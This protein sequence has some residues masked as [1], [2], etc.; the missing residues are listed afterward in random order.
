MPTYQPKR[1]TAQGIEEVSF[2]ISSI[3]GLQQ[4]LDNIE[5]SPSQSMP[6]I[7]VGSIT[8]QMGT[9]IIK[10]PGD[11]ESV[12]EL[13]EGE[14]SEA[15][16]E[17]TSEA[18]EAPIAEASEEP[19]DEENFQP[20]TNVLNALIISVEIISGK[21]Q[22]G[23]QVQVCTRTLFTYNKGR[24]RKMRLRKQW[25]VTITEANLENRFI[26][27]PIGGDSEEN[28]NCARLFNSNSASGG[29]FSP[30]YI[31]VRRPVFNDDG[32]EVDGLFSNIET[33]WKR[34]NPF[35]NRIYIK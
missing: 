18:P 35:T 31:R 26:F 32:Q 21:L 1:K 17:P 30:L 24:R 34:Y 14:V 2:P 13:A 19:I 28:A 5:T 27:I 16:E 29:T 8:D 25:Q 33:V 3:N 15:S 4:I 7:R 10:G 12:D 11:I 23:D 22:V 9:M 20:D 6:L